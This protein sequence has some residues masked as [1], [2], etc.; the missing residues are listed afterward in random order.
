MHTYLSALP[1][2]KATPVWWSVNSLHYD[3]S[4]VSSGLCGCRES[5]DLLQ[6]LG[7]DLGISAG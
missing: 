7:L 2:W 3:I 1:T 4:N 6:G 5:T